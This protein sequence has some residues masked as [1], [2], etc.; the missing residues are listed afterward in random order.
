MKKR[1]ILT[2]LNGKEAAKAINQ[3]QSVIS[4]LPNQ[5]PDRFHRPL[6][7]AARRKLKRLTGVLRRIEGE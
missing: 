7:T 2:I 1:D 6:L 5:V 4:R 3:Q